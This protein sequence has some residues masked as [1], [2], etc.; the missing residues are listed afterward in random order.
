MSGLEK[1]VISRRTYKGGEV[2]RGYKVTGISCVPCAPGSKPVETVRVQNMEEY[3]SGCAVHREGCFGHMCV[4]PTGSILPPHSLAFRSGDIRTQYYIACGWAFNRDD[5]RYIA[6]L[7]KTNYKKEGHLRSIMATPVS[8]SARL[9]AVP[10]DSEDYTIVYISRNLAEKVV[11]CLPERDE[12]GAEGSRYIER[13]LVEGDYVMLERPPSLTK[14]NN[15][16]FKLAYWDQEC[17][18]VHPA[19]FSFFHGDYDGDEVQLYALGTQAAIDEADAWVHP[20]NGGFAKARIIMQKE[21]PQVYPG[22]GTAGDL[23]FIK[24]TTV[25]FR[26]IQDGITN[27][28]LGNHTRN[29]DE[30]LEMFQERLAESPG[31]S[32]FLRDAR[33]GVESI[34]RQQLSQ[35]VIGDMSRVSR[36]SLMCFV[37]GESGGTFVVGRKSRIMLDRHTSPSSGSPAVRC[38]MLL[39]QK[40][41]QAALDA[42]RVGSKVMTTIDLVA[43]LLKGRLTTGNGSPCSTLYIMK[44]LDVDDVRS[45]LAASWAYETEGRV[46]AIAQDNAAGDDVMK[47]LVGSYSP[48]ILSRCDERDRRRVCRAAVNVVFSYYDLSPE[49]DDLTD[50]VIALTYRVGAS[51]LPITTRD[52]MLARGLGWMETLMACDY[53]KLPKLT[54]SVSK[55]WSATSA[56]MCAN[57]DMLP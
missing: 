37:R 23:E 35:G 14:F 17:V 47:H 57:F 45:T 7:K 13:H 33:E 27:T 40:A 48:V 3:S 32:T 11:F 31:T 49:E 42:H 34:M 46:I 38:S 28:P 24:Y 6:E 19:V 20:T 55:A 9:V 4:T 50:L 29:K 41:Q 44:G 52:G 5:D 2:H 56:T 16:P 22:T 12:S 25:S 43:N 10:H 1:T 18:G 30:H 39:C 8:G 53:T 21:F 51:T 36:I 15:Q 26:Q 54:N